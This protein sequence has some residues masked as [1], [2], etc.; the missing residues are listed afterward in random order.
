MDDISY[1]TA[2]GVDNA[3]LYV[4][5]RNNPI[6]YQDDSGN[7]AIT[8]FLICG[9]ILGG[10]LGGFT[11]YSSA[12]NRG[13]TGSEL[14]YSTFLG[15]ITGGTLGAL[16]GGV[17]YAGVAYSPKFIF[18]GLNSMANKALTDITAYATGG[19]APGGW[20]DY[21]TAFVY[22]GIMSKAPKQLKKGLDIYFRPLLNQSVSYGLHQ[23]A[24]DGQKYCYDITTRY[25]SADMTG[26]A[27][28]IARGIF[29]SAYN[30]QKQFTTALF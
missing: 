27:K 2:D 29:R 23:K 16:A 13:E 3:N 24:F 28:P 6:M 26:F 25:I 5:C 21:L 8:T 30:Y 17:I 22:G 9:A 18:D 1:L 7:F 20:E 11:A 4:Y 19:C 12:V 15:V 10:L 14:A